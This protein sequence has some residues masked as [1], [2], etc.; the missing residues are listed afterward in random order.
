MKSDIY[1]GDYRIVGIDDN[2]AIIVDTD[3]PFTALRQLIKV[4]NVGDSMM[5]I[6]NCAM[7]LAMCLN[8][9]M[10]TMSLHE[11]LIQYSADVPAVAVSSDDSIPF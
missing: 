9:D 8:A 3:V 6:D 7:M 10:N 2:T 11:A 4:S 1:A 5:N